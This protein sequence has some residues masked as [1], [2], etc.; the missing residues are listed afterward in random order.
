MGT[1]EGSVYCMAPGSQ[2][3]VQGVANNNVCNSQGVNA[4]M[5]H[6]NYSSCT[7]QD[8]CIRDSMNAASYGTEFQV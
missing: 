6:N 7:L 2:G 1:I 3:I 5:L 8:R 4:I